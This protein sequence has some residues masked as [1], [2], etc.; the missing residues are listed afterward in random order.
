[1]PQETGYWNPAVVTDEE[2]K[3]TVTFVVPD[4]ST[5]WQLAARGVTL[6]TLAGE[7]A[8]KLVVKKEL[9]GQLKLPSA[10]TDG[11]RTEVEVSVHNDLAAEGEIQV[12]LKTT[13]GSRTLED[14]QT[15]KVTSKGIERLS[16]PV[17]LKLPEA[18]GQTGAAAPQATDGCYAPQCAAQTLRHAGVCHGQ[19]VGQLGYHRLG[20]TAGRHAL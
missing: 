15:L 9:F 13:I 11:D 17:E 3:A 7:A 2:G 18:T 5:A 6:E 20:R 8:E 14:K 16:F 10:F 1:V 19:R 12:R 4:R